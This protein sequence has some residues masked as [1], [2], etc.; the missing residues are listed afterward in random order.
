ML[1][2]FTLTF[3]KNPVL[4]IENALFR[5]QPQIYKISYNLFRKYKVDFIILTSSLH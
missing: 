1:H 2:F 5:W 3:V 4:I